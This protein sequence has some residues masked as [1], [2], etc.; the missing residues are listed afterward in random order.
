MI[1]IAIIDD[2][3]M[4]REA[5]EQMTNIYYEEAEIVGMAENVEKGYQLII[6][7]KPDLVL[8]DIQMPD[9][10]GFDLLSKFSNIDFKVIFITAYNEHALNAFKYSAIDYI[11]KPV[12]PTDL[13]N[14]FDKAKE[15]IEKDNINLKL[16]AYFSNSKDTPRSEKKVV[17]KTSESIH[18]VKITDILRCESDSN[19]TR[20]FFTSGKSLIVAKTLKEYDE[21]LN[22]LGFIRVHQ[23]HLINFDF[24][25]RYD[26]ADGGSIMMAD[27]KRIPVSFRKKEQLLQFLNNF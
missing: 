16:E 22:P 7:K 3:K 5:I 8:L 1:K 11:L 17:L 6:E 2:E 24:I 4:A 15:S 13:S 21:I 12:D 19:Y 18:L 23:S 27:G 26:K 9:G 10:S 20:F 14:A 25:E